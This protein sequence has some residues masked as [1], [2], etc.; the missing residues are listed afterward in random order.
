M[1]SILSL[2]GK[3]EDV[4]PIHTIFTL[5]TEPYQLYLFKFESI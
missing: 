1:L 2:K 3:I 5:G 4:V